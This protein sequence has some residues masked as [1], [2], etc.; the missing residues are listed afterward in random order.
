ML[1]LLDNC[2]T[3]LNQMEKSISF[4]ITDYEYER[5]LK[6]AQRIERPISEVARQAIAD[7]T[8]ARIEAIHAVPLGTSSDIAPR[9]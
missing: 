6:L 4:R 5:L 7:Y 8:F 1:H 2:D 9:L 3:F